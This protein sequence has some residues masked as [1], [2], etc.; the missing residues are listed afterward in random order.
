[1]RRFSF[2]CCINRP[3]LA[4]R[5]LLASP[6]LRPEEGHQLILVGQATS[7]GDG[8]R[9][10][11]ALAKH[12]W[13][14]MVH[15]DVYLPL[16]W[17]RQFSEALDAVLFDQPRVA[18]VG[19]YGLQADAT[20][21]GHVYDRDRWIGEPL[22]QAQP[23][24]SLDELLVAVRVSSGLCP[25]PELGWHLYGTDVCLS[26]EARQLQSVVVDAPCEHRSTL[27]RIHPQMDESTRAQLLQVAQVYGDSAL[28]L[29]QRWPHATPI[30]TPVMSLTHDFRPEQLLAWVRQA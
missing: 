29:L 22:T 1:M 24:R 12:E 10:A 7:A 15:Q 16:G 20:H 17:D 28:A 21:V 27:P 13:L 14:V 5:C 25:A 3:E 2:V 26:A 6:C 9:T 18:V 4:Q 23:V 19:V 30:H 11:L 8:M